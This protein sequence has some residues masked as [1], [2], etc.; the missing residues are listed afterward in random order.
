MTNGSPSFRKLLAL[1]VGLYIFL[2]VLYL[3]AI[4]VGE[5][6][7]EP[8]H[9]QCIEQVSQFN[10]LP[11]VEPKPEG[12]W[13]SREY[14]TSGIMCYHMPLY[15]V[16]GGNVQR[17]VAA[18]TEAPLHFEFPPNNPEFIGSG[19]MFLH[20][21]KPT[22]WLL[23]EPATLIGLRWLSIGLG[24]IVLWACFRVAR[25]VFPGHDMIAVL[26]MTMA[27]GWPQ[28]VYLSRAISND[29]LAT[30]I[31]VVI[32]VVLLSVGRPNRFIGAA[33]LSVLAVWTKLSVLFAVG[34][35]LGAWLLEFLILRAQKRLYIRALLACLAIWGI[36]WAVIMVEPTL[37]KNFSSSTGRF[38]AVSP[39]ANTLIYWQNFIR[40]TLS[41]GWARFGWMSVPAPLW[42]AYAWWAAILITGVAG[43]FASWRAQYT[44][45]KKLVWFI[46][47]MWGAGL[48]VSYMQINLNRLQPQFRFLLTALP[49]IT[50]FSAA[51]LLS[52]PSK[53]I[54]R[55]RT[56]IILLALFLLAYN[57]WFVIAIIK[58]TYGWYWL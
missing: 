35:V 39:Q 2:S 10:R 41:S 16:I 55:D 51:G 26:S 56:I 19:V 37:Y 1:P 32:L 33:A 5:S 14:I 46:L 21:E 20:E 58:P 57:L 31:G 4:P 47:A 30:A 29:V 13:F 44:K 49:I 43:L 12:R 40:L 36:G 9:I 27:A 23:P 22:L 45:Q 38:T 8:G 53:Q 50:T 25:R 52:W 15:Y 48:L 6:P 34:A 18:V 11:I 54:R 42:H 28:F 24:A 3:L 17:A 7:D